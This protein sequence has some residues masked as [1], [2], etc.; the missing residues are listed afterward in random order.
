MADGDIN[1][2]AVA[3]AIIVII[4]ILAWTN[5]I[6]PL[7][8]AVVEL[9]GAASLVWTGLAPSIDALKS[10]LATMMAPS[11]ADAQKTL[12][13]A[14]TAA[15]V[16]NAQVDSATTALAATPLVKEQLQKDVA[17]ASAL[18]KNSDKII[19]DAAANRPRTI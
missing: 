16:L 3:A 13:Q 17:A 18:I 1:W 4:L 8:K 11:V 12:Q 10:W 2:G 15:K 14:D 19:T 5:A 6:P 9:G 7:T